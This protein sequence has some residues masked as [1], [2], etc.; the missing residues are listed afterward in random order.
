[1]KIRIASSIALA[2]ALALGATGCSL[3]AP[4]GTL[5]PYAPSDGVDVNVEGIDVRNILL[6]ADETG[7][8]FNV[9]YTAMNRTGQEQVITMSFVAENGDKAIAEF[10][11]PVG[12]TAF[13][14]PAGEVAPV[15]VSMPGLMVGSTVSTY[16]QLAGAPEVEHNVPVLDGTLAE[17]RDYVLPANFS[18]KADETADD[19]K[20]VAEDDAAS[21]S[22]VGD[23]IEEDEK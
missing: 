11:V 14:N 3:I 12:T 1:M 20:V 9:V 6:V 16:F 4:Q 5:E 15:L 10:T 21:Q 22:K 18:Q 19:K 23:D 7:E 8:N 17:Y 2:A 13:G